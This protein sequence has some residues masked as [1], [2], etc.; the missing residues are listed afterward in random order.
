M[1]ENYEKEKTKQQ[2]VP[3]FGENINFITF[4]NKMKIQLKY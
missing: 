1:A 4:I 3:S 2:V